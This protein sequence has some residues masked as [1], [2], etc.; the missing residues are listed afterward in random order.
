[1]ALV[2]DRGGHR[3]R[4]SSMR[5]F[6]ALFICGDDPDAGMG[7]GFSVG[8][9]A[10]P[11]CDADFQLATTPVWYGDVIGSSH[12][13]IVDD[14]FGQASADEP[15]KKAYLAATV[16]WLRWQLAADQTMKPLFVGADC[17]YCKQTSTWKLQSKKL[18]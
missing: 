3:A 10:R 18:D 13:T 2:G 6:A 15:L 7:D 17:G 12:T 11:N 16:A 14:A 1:L 8:D 4:S 9:V 5:G